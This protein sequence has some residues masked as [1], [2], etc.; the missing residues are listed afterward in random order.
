MIALY[1]RQSVDK[2]DSISISQQLEL[3]RYEARG[4]PAGALRIVATAA[5]IRSA[6]PSGK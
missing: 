2:P 6:L 3:C 1:A 5:R 4:R